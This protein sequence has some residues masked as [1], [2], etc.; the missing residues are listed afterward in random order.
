MDRD[1]LL[2][3]VI[4]H[5][6]PFAWWE[7]DVIHNKVEFNDLKVT[8]LGYRVEDFAGKG[9][10]AFTDILHPDDYRKTMDAMT[11]LLTGRKSIYQT[12]YRIRDSENRYH[13]YMD[14]GVITD[15]IGRKISRVRG[16]VIDLG[17]ERE[18][19][20]NVDGIVELLQKHAADRDAI[21]IVCAGCVRLKIDKDEWTPL[22]KGLAAAITDTVSH[23]IC[24][25]CLRALYPELA[26]RV[27]ENLAK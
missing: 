13:W 17:L 12:D 9:Y 20:T 15:T 21:L 16:I 8:A 1:A 4:M 2:T 23:G 22:S 3:D 7:W 10:Q 5:H 26:D 24:P 27:L 18:M 6:S 11:D 14:R 19:G 25:D